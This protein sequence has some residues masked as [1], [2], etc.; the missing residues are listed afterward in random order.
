[1]KN[2]RKRVLFMRGYFYPEVAA[3]N[4]MCLELA[5]ALE[6]NGYEVV[7]LSPIPTRG[8]SD[9]VR[10]EYYDKREELISSHIMV[11][12]FWLPQEGKNIIARFLRYLLQNVYQVFFALNNKYDYLFMYS[13][14]PTNGFV[15]S[16]C[17]VIKRKPFIYYLHD[18]FPDSLVNVGITKEGSMLW[19]FGR[20]LENFSYKY[21]SKIITISNEIKNNIKNKGVCEN[22]IDIVPN[23]V[24]A[25]AIKEIKRENNTLFDEYGIEREK[26]IV[27]YAGNIGKA[28]GI[29]TLLEA[30]NL[31]RENKKLLFVIIGNG[32][33]EEECKNFVIQ[34]E[35]DNIKFLPMQS[36]SRIS[37]VYSLGD[38]SVVS[39]KKGFGSA[40]VPSKTCN[41][42][43]VS[44]PIIAS[45]DLSSE[46]SYIIKEYN[47][48]VCV[49]PEKP[50]L[51]ADA[52]LKLYSEREN[53]VEMGRRGR[54]YLIANMTKKI[55]TK[56]IVDIISQI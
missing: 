11:K 31:L 33:E 50:N 36:I 39:C 34:N 30:A 6:D 15:G 44:R 56:R 53:C 27:T 28:Q 21:A 20:I 32:A 23:W 2:D 9:G 41:I 51:L 52:I 55:C 4:Q 18:V 10:K 47:C 12:R 13:T 35:I 49:Q 8:V 29:K 43:A 42:M 1:M 45:Y 14:P 48:G 3:S 37:E 26:F 25:T 22:K 46:L 16:L 40:C 54:E 5:Q 7:I 19:K 38:A 17:S 24:D